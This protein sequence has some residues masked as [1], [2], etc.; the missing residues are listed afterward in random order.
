MCI[1]DRPCCV[2]WSPENGFHSVWGRIRRRARHI[3]HDRYRI[4]YRKYTL[5]NR[6]LMKCIPPFPGGMHLYTG[7]LYVW[8][9]NKRIIRKNPAVGVREGLRKMLHE[10]H[11]IYCKRRKNDGRIRMGRSVQMC[12]RDSLRCITTESSSR[13]RFS[14][15]A[16]LKK[17]WMKSWA[18]GVM[19]DVYKRQCLSIPHLR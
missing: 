12:I 16:N 4:R 7:K 13:T 9:R 5:Y 19:I 1:R 3:Q 2:E 8:K 11:P 10:H 6:I 15:L 18:E 14:P 17:S